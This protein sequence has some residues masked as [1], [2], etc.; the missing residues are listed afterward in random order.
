M[1]RW[2][3]AH[4]I[5]WMYHQIDI[6]NVHL[7]IRALWPIASLM[8][9][10][11]ASTAEILLIGVIIVNDTNSAEMTKGAISEGALSLMDMASNPKALELFVMELK[12]KG[13]DG[14]SKELK[15]NIVEY[16]EALSD[17]GKFP[18]VRVPVNTGDIVY[19]TEHILY[20][21]YY[22]A[23]GDE[24]EFPFKC[25]VNTVTI[26]KRAS[27]GGMFSLKYDIDGHEVTVT[28]GDIGTRVFLTKEDALNYIKGGDKDGV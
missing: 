8:G 26:Y 15:D 22:R 1:E 4:L 6:P 14:L 19:M 23:R 25:V 12:K 9:L 21:D 11:Y 10:C 2:S 16:F 13:I 20:N 3:V 18:F 27:G 7:A 28:F 24:Y 5:P 17:G